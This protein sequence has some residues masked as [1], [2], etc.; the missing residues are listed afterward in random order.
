M[1]LAALKQGTVSAV[2][3]IGKTLRGVLN[4]GVVVGGGVFTGF[5][6]MFLYSSNL[7]LN[8]TSAAF[9]GFLTGSCYSAILAFTYKK[10]KHLKEK[11]EAEQESNDSGL[12]N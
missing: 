3:K 9:I 2:K 12:F 4:A 1:K 10:E 11:L 7:K 8:S 5:G 6:A